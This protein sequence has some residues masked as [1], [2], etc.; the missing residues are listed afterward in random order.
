MKSSSPSISADGRFVSLHSE[1]N[2]LVPDD[3]NNAYDIFVHD[4][5]TGETTRVN[6]DSEGNQ[7]NYYASAVSSISDNGRYVAFNTFASNLVP[8]DTNGV[9]DVFVHDR[10]TGETTRVSLNS[11]G[12]EGNNVSAMPSISGDGR[13]VTFYSYATNLV[14]DDTNGYKDIFV[15]DRDT[16]ETRRASVDSE[17]NEANSSSHRP[18]ISADG[19]YV[20]FESF[21]TNLVPEDTYSNYA[22]NEIYA[23]GP[24]IEKTLE[25]NIDIAPRREPNRINPEHGRLSVAILSD[26]SFDAAQVDAETVRFGPNQAESIDGRMADIDRD[27]DVDLILRFVTEETGITCGDTEVSLIGETFEGLK[28]VGIDSIL[29]MGCRQSTDD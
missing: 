10:E 18:A 9:T 22:S 25:V 23:H 14:P 8:D 15:Y 16:G 27:G 13:Y 29:T 24:M 2:N 6:L 1:A 21:A 19:S 5:L 12:I 7:A 26:E 28:I 3:T 20:A 4:R 11:E 17:G